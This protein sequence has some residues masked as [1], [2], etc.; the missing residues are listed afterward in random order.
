MKKSCFFCNHLLLSLILLYCLSLCWTACGGG[1]PGT[2]PNQTP[3]QNLA[4]LSVKPDNNDLIRALQ[5]KWKNETNPTVWI[6]IT[7]NKLKHWNGDQISAESEIEADGPC[8]S[9]PCRTDS[10][11]LADGWCFTEKGEFDV[12][13][14]RV[15]QC[16]KTKLHI[17]QT[18]VPENSFVYLRAE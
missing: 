1:N 4:P 10:T 13:C 6:E 5:G 11:V 7:G 17:S 14:Y 8:E 15:L 16:D 18:D 2:T 9:L 3:G 12:V